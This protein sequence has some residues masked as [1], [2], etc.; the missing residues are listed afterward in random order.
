MGKED[1]DG[2]S[3]EFLS[4]GQRTQD[5]YLVYYIVRGAHLMG[6]RGQGEKRAATKVIITDVY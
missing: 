2:G 3:F 5:R 6:R 4:D 1:E